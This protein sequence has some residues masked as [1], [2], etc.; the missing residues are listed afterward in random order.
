MFTHWL[1][2][3][4]IVAIRFL[5][6]GRLQTLFIVAGVALGVAVIVF[7]SALMT[8]LQSN[9]IHRMLSA[10]AHIQLLP[11]QEIS[12]PLRSGVAASA[13]EVEGAIVQPPLQRLKSIDQ[14]QPIAAQI[15]AMPD[16]LF[17]SPVA[18]GT[19]LV[20]RGAASRAVTTSG[21]EPDTYFH[22]VDIGSKIVRGS[23][24][25]TASDVL[26][27]TELASDLGVDVGDKLRVT[28]A[29]DAASTLTI[30]GIF[31]LGN[32]GANQRTTYMALHTAQSLLGLPGGATS[33]EVTVRDVFAAEAIAQRITTAT[34][35]EADS[36]IK[37]NAQFFTALSAQSTSNS[38]IRFFVGLSV[39]FGI[40]SVLAVVVVQKSR[41]IGILRAMGIS[42]AQI[43]RLFL[44]QGGLLGLSGSIV[45]SAIGALGLALWERSAKN[46]DGTPLFPLVLDP[47]LFAVALLLATFIGLIAAVAPARRAARLDPVVAIRG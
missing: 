9:L 3:E 45:G 2:F 4:W 23:S 32:K 38:A 11:P 20:V 13:D 37:T 41:E 35:V 40:A 26:I 39:A 22:I 42:Q 44:L 21:I 36:W 29:D 33:L 18:G 12:R 1:P 43:L 6:E 27:G 25:L 10:Q 47:S 15:G 16:V 28:T 46:A 19:A 34:G 17:V 8:G 5:R 30:A 24:R 7:M 31:D 14:W